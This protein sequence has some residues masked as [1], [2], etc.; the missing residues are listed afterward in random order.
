M[1]K[2]IIVGMLASLFLINNMHADRGGSSFLP[3]FATGAVAGSLLTAAT[4]RP[5]REVIVERE[6]TVTE[7]PSNRKVRRLERKIEELQDEI[8]ELTH[9]NRRLLREI[10]LLKQA[11]K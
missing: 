2:K 3:G 8:D 6:T 5:R 11:Q 9:E 1:L 4:T 10:K 7:K